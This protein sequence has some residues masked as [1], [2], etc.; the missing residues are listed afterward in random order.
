MNARIRRF[1]R[2]AE[3]RAAF[4]SRRA[5]LAPR[6]FSAAGVRPQIIGAK[7]RAVEVA[8]VRVKRSKELAIASRRRNGR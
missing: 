3:K 8:K 2:R 6:G 7:R 1:E 5:E 4:H